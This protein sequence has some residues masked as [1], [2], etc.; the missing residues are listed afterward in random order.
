MALCHIDVSMSSVH[1]VRIATL[2]LPRPATE[3]RAFLLA[4]RRQPAPFDGPN[5]FR[6]LCSANDQVRTGEM[7]TA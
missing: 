7:L 5:Q 2:T 3:L 1:A 4:C 6:A